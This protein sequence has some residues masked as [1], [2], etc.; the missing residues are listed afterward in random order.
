MPYFEEFGME[1]SAKMGQKLQGYYKGDYGSL[2]IEATQ[3]HE[4]GTVTKYKGGPSVLK[5]RP[6][7]GNP[8]DMPR[9]REVTRDIPQEFPEQ[10]L[11]EKAGSRPSE[12]HGPWENY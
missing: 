12:E 10:T 4:L 6:I 3:E 7:Y 9:E 5:M 2:P 8:Q 1:L 11:A